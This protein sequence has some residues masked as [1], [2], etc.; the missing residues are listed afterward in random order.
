MFA[1]NDVRQQFQSLQSK[2]LAL[3]KTATEVKQVFDASRQQALN[4]AGVKGE[5]IGHP[6]K[7]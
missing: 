1:K 6:A 5:D 4:Q 2:S 3:H 7:K